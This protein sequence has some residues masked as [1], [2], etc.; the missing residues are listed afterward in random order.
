MCGSGCP[1]NRGNS[2]LAAAALQGIRG[3]SLR[4]D[5]VDNALRTKHLRRKLVA[6]YKKLL[7]IEPSREDIFTWIVRWVATGESP[8]TQ[9]R[10]A[11]RRELDDASA[12]FTRE[13]LADLPGDWHDIVDMIEN[14]GKD[15]VE[16]E[17]CRWAD[18]LGGLGEDFWTLEKTIDPESLA[19]GL[20]DHYRLRG[21]TYEDAVE[22]LAAAIAGSGVRIG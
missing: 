20:A 7:D 12:Y 1:R 18:A 16:E 2:N 9:A 14:A 8:I 22:Q 10:K 11:A 5:A 13:V 17:L 19:V 6:A 15:G 4:H 21:H 3:R